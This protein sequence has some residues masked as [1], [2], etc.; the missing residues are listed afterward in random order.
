MKQVILVK[1]KAKNVFQYTA[2]M[3]KH[4]G[5]KKLKDLKYHRQSLP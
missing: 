1:G 2:L 4:Q 3:A 5:H